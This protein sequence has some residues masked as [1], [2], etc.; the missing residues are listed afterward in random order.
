MSGAAHL[1]VAEDVGVA[2][3]GCPVVTGASFG[4]D[5][6]RL[7]ALVGPNGAGKTTLL[8]ALGGLAPSTGRITLAG[9]DID[10][11]TP[12]ERARRIAF[13]PQGH[14]VHWPLSARDVVALG[15]YPHGVND[16][17]RMGP[18]DAALVD[19]AMARTDATAFA[20]RQVTTLSGGERA[21][22][23]LARVFAVGAPILL[24]DE[25][26][27]ALDPRH[28]I[29]IMAALKEEAGRGALVIAVTHDL[30]L[31]ARMADEV[32]VID[33]GRIVARGAP[34]AVLTPTLLR[35]VYGVEALT[36]EHAGEPVIVPWTAP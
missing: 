29:G 31:A 22:V 15:R 21:R 18:R 35:D 17:A 13:L 23:M 28:Q 11:L 12:P 27:A 33:R 9:T 30:G 8:R 1:L 14:V 3:G 4:L 26:T 25:P 2:Y 20:G 10:A 24:A 5:A 16:P 32:M 36:L 6:G 7:V 19:E 34:R